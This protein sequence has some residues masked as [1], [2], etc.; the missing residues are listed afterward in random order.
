[1]HHQRRE[2]GKRKRPTHLSGES[3]FRSLFEDHLRARGTGR[4]ALR[5]CH[6]C[7]RKIVGEGRG[8][9]AVRLRPPPRT[10]HHARDAG[11]GQGGW[12]RGL[13][14]PLLTDRRRR[15]PGPHLLGER[16]RPRGDVGIPDI[17]AP[18]ASLRVVGLTRSGA[19]TTGHGSGRDGPAPWADPHAP[20]SPG[21]SPS[22]ERG[23]PA[24]GPLQEQEPRYP[25]QGGPGRV[26]ASR[27]GLRSGLGRSCVA[28]VAATA[29]DRPGSDRAC[30]AADA[31][32]RADVAD[33]A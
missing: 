16:T 26:A 21:R 1:M 18:E 29:P 11:G 4:A 32:I 23:P 7:V 24:R 17:P 27:S 8:G 14:P 13:S 20:S 28:G 25:P 12:P 30:V 3:E 22:R 19:L 31:A 15:P 5:C 33:G 9:G 2:W 6:R 10:C